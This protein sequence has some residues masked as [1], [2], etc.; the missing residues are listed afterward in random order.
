MSN[1]NHNAA[2]SSII[3][4]SRKSQ[5]FV[6]GADNSNGEESTL[7]AKL[8]INSPSAPRRTSLFSLVA[9]AYYYSAKC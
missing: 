3:E 1:N 9:D 2:H 4:L 5:P 7:K 6:V 8:I